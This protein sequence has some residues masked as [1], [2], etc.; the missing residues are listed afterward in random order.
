MMDKKHLGDILTVNDIKKYGKKIAIIAG[1]GAGK[2]TFVWEKLSQNNKNVLLITSRAAIRD[3]TIQDKNNIGITKNACY[4]PSIQ[5]LNVKTH[6]QLYLEIKNCAN[7]KQIYNLTSNYDYIVI[8]EAH[9]IITDSFTDSAF[10][11]W[12]FINHISSSQL[13]NSTIILLSATLDP[14]KVKLIN[15]GWKILDYTNQCINIKP[16]KYSIINQHQVFTTI[17]KC[18][19]NNKVVYMANSA[20]GIVEYIKPQLIAEGIDEDSIAVIMSGDK[21]KSLLTQKEKEI[22]D[23]CYNH[24]IKFNSLPQEINILLTTT[25]LKEG[26]NIFDENIKSIYCE[27]QYYVDIIQFPGRIRN[28]VDTVFIVDDAQQ[29]KNYYEKLEYEY[30][31]EECE[32]ANKK[33][34]KL[35][36]DYLSEW[37]DYSNKN[38]CKSNLKIK[39]F[40]EFIEKKF[41]FI[42]FNYFTN[43]FEVYEQKRQAIE[44]HKNAIKAYN[45]V[46]QEYIKWHTGV[47]KIVIDKKNKEE[48]E[49]E[50]IDSYFKKNSNY[51]NKEI[52]K[53]T[54]NK[55]L[56]D[57]NALGIKNS[58]NKPYKKIKDLLSKNKYDITEKGKTSNPKITI[59]QI[60]I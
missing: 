17:K 36:E 57:L 28:G 20:K 11:L 60:V 58:K 34:L 23:N 49:K 37:G 35:A 25:K 30:A 15:D 32:N 8:D 42:K 6:A 4:I 51:I 54:R 46:S 27:S 9:S 1:V 29:H 41:M 22:S 43:R 18:N 14:I 53:E 55:I 48:L 33:L 3:E 13:Y 44:Q 26:I 19:N 16:N 50:L 12:S 10:H 21:V 2:N 38:W 47:E 5:N 59:T 45:N 24:I 52:N 56:A 39:E 31:A 40:K 7:P